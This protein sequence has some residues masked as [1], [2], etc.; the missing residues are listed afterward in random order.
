MSGQAPPDWTDDEPGLSTLGAALARGVRRSFHRAWLVVLIAVAATMS[1]VVSRA[2]SP[3][4]Y[5][6]RVTLR[7]VET[8]IERRDVTRLPRD[9]RQSLV[10]GALTSTRLAAIIRD[11]ELYP[12]LAKTDMASAVASLRE[13]M[14]VDVTSNFFLGERLPDDPP[15]SARVDLA[16][17]AGTAD[18][19][20]AVARDLG[21]AILD[22]EK[23]Q[24]VAASD[25]SVRV[26]AAALDTLAAR[27]ATLAEE[28]RASQRADAGGP[29]SERTVRLQAQERAQMDRLRATE[30]QRTR[31]ELMARAEGA[32]LGL[33]I[34]RVYEQSTKRGGASVA[35]LGFLFVILMLMFLP[36]AALVVGTFDS[37]IRDE[38][39]VART[40]VPLLVQLP[41]PVPPGAK[42]SRRARVGGMG[43]M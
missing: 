42:R 11:R 37:R 20:L 6:A 43:P 15:R 33:T 32:G 40:G 36:L 38:V 9:L 31:L 29:A 24:R 39:D 30:G 10:G 13:D 7:V 16:F 41:R 35:S 21:D 2:T 25:A 28:R 19:A 17:T 26:I 5:T 34:D 12:R 27:L 1:I 8:T 3:R 14:G 18:V 23:E 22:A 4:R